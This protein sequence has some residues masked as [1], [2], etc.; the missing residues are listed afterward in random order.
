[1]PTGRPRAFEIDKVLS[2]ASTNGGGRHEKPV[3][4]PR[5]GF[6]VSLAFDDPSSIRLIDSNGSGGTD[7]SDGVYSLHYPFST[8]KPPVLV[9][10]A[11][12]F[13]VAWNN[14]ECP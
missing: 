11:L 12:A 14:A 13:W 2:S 10:S 5:L 4:K 7:L 1:M 3:P 6:G 8:G 9:S